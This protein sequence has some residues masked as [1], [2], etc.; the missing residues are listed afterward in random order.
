ML[1]SAHT[2]LD[3]LLQAAVARGAVPGVVALVADHERV[4]YRGAFGT[5]DDRRAGAMPADAL[6]RIQSMIKPRPR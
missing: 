6:F 5:L 1:L 3:T 2:E 4:L